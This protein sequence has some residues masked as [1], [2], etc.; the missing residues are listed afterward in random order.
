MKIKNKAKRNINSIILY[1]NTKTSLKL[2][3]EANRS[4]GLYKPKIYK[5]KIYKMK[6]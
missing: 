6:K 3:L 4:K 1:K 5:I 2:I